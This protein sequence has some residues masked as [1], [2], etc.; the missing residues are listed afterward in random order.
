MDFRFVIA[1]PLRAIAGLCQL[2]FVNSEKHWKHQ[3]KAQAIEWAVS[4]PAKPKRAWLE[5]YTFSR[6]SGNSCVFQPAFRFVGEAEK[7]LTWEDGFPR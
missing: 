2:T 1:C 6:D 7:G 3:Y 4:V 5:H